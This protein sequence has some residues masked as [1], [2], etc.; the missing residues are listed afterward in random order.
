VDS[1]RIAARR[2][3]MQGAELMKWLSKMAA[4]CAKRL[5]LGVSTRVS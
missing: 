3:G 1:P 4:R 5:K 2:A